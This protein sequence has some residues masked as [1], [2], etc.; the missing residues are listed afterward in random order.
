[1]SPLPT[2]LSCSGFELVSRVLDHPEGGI[3]ALVELAGSGETDWLEFKAAMVG[4]PED[5]RNPKENDADGHWNVAEAVLAMANSRGGVVFL[6]VDDN[7]NAVGIAAGDPRRV[8]ETR[9]MDAFLRMEVLERIH[10][11]NSDCRW[12]TGLKG[13]WELERPWPP[14]QFVIRPLQFQGKPIAA[15]LVRP[16][17]VGNGCLIATQNGEERL[18]KRVEGNLGRVE[19]L[20]GRVAIPQYERARCTVGEDLGSLLMRFLKRAEKGGTKEED[21][22]AAIEAWHRKFQK[23]NADLNHT[24]IPLDAEERFHVEDCFESVLPAAAFEPQAEEILP[25]YISEDWMEDDFDDRLEHE[26]LE[27]SDDIESAEYSDAPSGHLESPPP[28]RVA[29]RGGLFELL[30]EEPRTVLVGEPGGGKTTCLRRLTLESV[31]QYQ[32]GQNVTLF[33]PMAKWA[34][35]G[36][37]STLLRS[38]TGLSMGQVEQLIS[39]NRCRLLFDGLNECPDSLRAAAINELTALLEN[40][41]NLPLVI[42]TRSVESVTHLRLSTFSVQPLSDSQQIKFLSAY[43]HDFERASKLFEQIQSKPGAETFATNPLLLRMIVEVAGKDGELPKGRALLYRCWLHDWYRREREKAVRAKDPLP[44]SEKETLEGL[45]AIALAARMRGARIATE[46]E[47]LNALEC[48]VK[49]RG[50]FLRRMTQSP[51]LRRDEG[52]FQFRHETVQEYLCAEALILRPNALRN[53]GSERC[54]TWGMPLAYAAELSDPLPEDLKTAMWRIAPWLAAVLARPEDTVPSLPEPLG[55]LTRWAVNQEQPSLSPR[56]LIDTEWYR[57]ESTL[58][59]AVSEPATRWRHWHSFEVSQ[60]AACQTDA[61]LAAV[62]RR[63]LTV[64]SD[65]PYFGKEERTYLSSRM[66]IEQGIRLISEGTLVSGD[67]SQEKRLQLLTNANPAQ[68]VALANAGI[69]SKDDFSQEKRLQLLAASDP[70][71][72]VCLFNKGL[73]SKGDFSQEKRLQL[74]TNANSTQAIALVNAG[75]L[76]KDDFSQEKRLQLLAN[77]KPAEAV[78][79][80]DAGLFS[81]GD[82]SQEK[83]LQLLTKSKPAQAVA[84]FNEGL[85][86]KGELLTTSNLRQAVALVNAGILSKDDFSQEKRL[87]LLAAAYPAQVIA[88]VNAGILSKDDFSQEKRLR[89]LGRADPAQAVA[90][91]KAGILSKDDFSQKKRHKLIAASYPGQVPALVNAGILSKDDFSHEKRRQLLADASPELARSLVNAG[92]LPKD[93]FLANLDALT[94]YRLSSIGTATQIVGLVE[95]GILSPEDFDPEGRFRLA[96]LADGDQVLTLVKNGILAREDFNFESRQHLAIHAASDLKR[97]MSFLGAGLLIK[98][99]FNQYRH[100]ITPDMTSAAEI[101]TAPVEEAL[102]DQSLREK[103]QDWLLDKI[104]EGSITRLHPDFGFLKSDDFPADIFSHRSQWPLSC[105]EYQT[106]VG[107][108]FTAKLGF[109]QKKKKW[110][111]VTAMVAADWSVFREPYRS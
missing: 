69:L 91:V 102:E 63:M 110:N 80:F 10:P 48:L 36:G 50:E 30:S 87:Q 73:V 106:G 100:W 14:D 7:A 23:Q 32:R 13:L 47:A 34:A 41:P 86:S 72:A 1:M 21:L 12:S 94:R 74:L 18:I 108:L 104:F 15:L 88:L 68:A 38:T 16:V 78:A 53:Q 98:E 42:S 11:T 89:H 55:S 24:F 107:F 79:L 58:R 35:S 82:F 99:D 59:Y 44:W 81:K 90:L 20:R 4:R 27:A 49:N 31:V 96:T 92:I 5:R 19:Y 103:T 43:L 56:L 85:F 76:S 60:L 39:A 8:L 111:Y 109:S 83:W 61:I 17:P 45:S 51:L 40:Y 6:G 25:D 75:I 9:G 95:A 33:L 101:F 46:E 67:F 26:D 57:L 52:Q 70:T 54:G 97:A 65:S 3:K 62:L 22:E 2:P 71:D 66:G 84:L 77:P 64:R 28:A 29:R 93:S 37:L 105:S